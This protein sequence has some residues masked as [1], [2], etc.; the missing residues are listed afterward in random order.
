MKRYVLMFMLTFCACMSLQ[1]QKVGMKV[2]FLGTGAAD[3]EGIDERGEIRRCSSILVDGA[4]LVDLTVQAVDM[5]PDG[6]KPEVIFYTHSHRDHFDPETAVKLGVSRVYV[7]ASWIGRAQSKFREASFRLGLPM[8]KVIPIETQESVCELGLRVT[9]LPANHATSDLHE[10]ALIYLIEKDGV[11]VLYATDTAGLMADATQG[12]G[13]DAHKGPAQPIHGFI[14][15]ATMGMDGDEDYRIFAH[16]SVGTV[17]RTVHVLTKTGRYTPPEGM[18]V[19]LT[20][21]ARTLHGTQAELDATLPQ[22]LKAAYDGLE[23]TFEM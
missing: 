7:G 8:P 18:P 11:R 6:C 15:E 21:L 10:Q 5:I 16:S 4:V 13:I 14:M 17:L 23:V 2:L 22:P 20:H 9:A 19:Y 3:W 1:A 12:I